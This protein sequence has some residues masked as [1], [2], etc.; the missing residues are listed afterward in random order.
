MAEKLVRVC[1]ICGRPAEQS[2]TFKVG[3]R[4]RAQ[5]LC[6][7]HLQELVSH[8]HTAKRGRRPALKPSGAA[9]AARGSAH[10]GPTKRNPKPSS[11]AKRPRKRI[12]DP[13]V[14]E[15]RR[16]ALE[17]ARRVRAQSRAAARQAV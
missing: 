16:A 11:T 10:R 8:S 12:T 15:K 3:P 5:D 4:S 1:D 9:P 13:A 2:V 14:L 17:K 7:T 6:G